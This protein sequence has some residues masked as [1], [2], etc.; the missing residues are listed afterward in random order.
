MDEVL[1]VA[2]WSDYEYVVQ[3]RETGDRIEGC[4]SLDEAR[5]VLAR[6]YAEDEREGILVE[7]FYEIARWDCEEYYYK[8]IE[9]W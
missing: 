9:K 2:Y 6:F 7:D 3:C 5:E 4:A 8:T 1:A